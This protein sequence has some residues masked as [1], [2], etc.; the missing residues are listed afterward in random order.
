M[1]WEY[2]FVLGNAALVAASLLL[3]RYGGKNL[4]LTQGILHILTHGRIWL[5]GIFLGWISG[6]LFSFVLT[7][8][9]VTVAASLYIPLVYTI[10][11]W[12]GV[13][14]LKESVDI[15]KIL[16]SIAIIIGLCVFFKSGSLS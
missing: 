13:L 7:R 10:T 5:F 8:V 9:N 11:F 2:F 6:L 1:R 14:F 15:Y 12:C 4:D 3:T 16:G